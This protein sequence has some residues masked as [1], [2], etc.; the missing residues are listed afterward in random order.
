[1][2]IFT[3]PNGLMGVI[4]SCVCVVVRG[5]QRIYQTNGFMKKK[6]GRDVLVYHISYHSSANWVT[7]HHESLD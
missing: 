7:D 2:T 6:V 3:L 5:F 4:A 1:M